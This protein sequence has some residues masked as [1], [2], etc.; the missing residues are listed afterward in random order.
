MFTI[1]QTQQRKEKKVCTRHRSPLMGMGVFIQ[2]LKQRKFC[3]GAWMDLE[4]IMLSEV[5]S[6]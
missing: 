4:G 5:K 1:C 2:P 3:Q 6:V